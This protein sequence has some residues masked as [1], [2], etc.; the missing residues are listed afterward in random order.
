VPRRESEEI[1]RIHVWLYTRDVGRIDTLFPQVS[2][3]KI[4]RSIV[5]ST[6]D[7]IEAKLT[8]IR[9]S[10]LPIAPVDISTLEATVSED[11]GA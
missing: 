10:A 1:E 4:I 11:E 2:R 9:D 3:N 8:D 5:R 7:N 6:L